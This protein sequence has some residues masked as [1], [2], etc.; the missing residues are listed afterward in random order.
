MRVAYLRAIWSVSPVNAAAVLT[1]S[2][3]EFRSRRYLPPQTGFELMTFWLTVIVLDYCESASEEP[4][5][6]CGGPRRSPLLPMHLFCDLGQ[7]R[8]VVPL[9]HGDHLSRL[10]ACTFGLRFGR[11][12]LLRPGGLVGRPGYRATRT[13]L[14]HVA[15][16]G[17][18]ATRTARLGTAR[19]VKP[20]FAKAVLEKLGGNWGYP[21]VHVWVN[22]SRDG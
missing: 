15:P 21:D 2:R 20:V 12:R 16:E 8:A 13:H 3:R 5:G 6:S 10:A 11:G 17:G 18:G 9:E 19:N 4:G 1:K 22:L 7:R 14:A